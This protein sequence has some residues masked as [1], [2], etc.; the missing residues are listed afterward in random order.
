MKILLSND[1]GI[2]AE[3]LKTLARILGRDHEV[4]VCAP[5][6]ERSSASHSVTYYRMVN[7]AWK[8][9]TEGAVMAWA[10][11]GTPADCVFYGLNCFLK[12]EVDIVITGINKGDNLSTDVSYSGTVGAAV[13]ALCMGVPAM[14]VSL[15]SPIKTDYETAAEIVKELMPVYLSD[16]SCRKY[17][18]NVN[19]PSVARENILGIRITQ[20][21]GFKD[22]K[23]SI[24][25]EEQ[26]DGSYRL[27]CRDQKPSLIGVGECSDGDITAVRQGYVSV[28]PVGL[29]CVDHH[30]CANMRAWEKI[31]L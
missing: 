9:E 7:R 23:K 18:C 3:G 28:T 11:D 25:A 4:Y 1:D 6:G 2:E 8:K 26:E 27:I 5:E 31:K 24:I 15:C 20:F 17:V 19:V 30:R 13:E 14:A 10:V 12:D 21:D 16:P 29:D 22:F